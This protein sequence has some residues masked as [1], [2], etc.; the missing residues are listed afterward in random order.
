MGEG[1]C[2]GGDSVPCICCEPATK[3]GRS[4]LLERVERNR[5]ITQPTLLGRFLGRFLDGTSEMV[6]VSKGSVCLC[7]C[8]VTR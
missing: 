2:Y 1:F 3:M 6:N 4:V 8:D 7:W 5:I